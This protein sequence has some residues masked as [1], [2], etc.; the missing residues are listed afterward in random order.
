[1]GSVKRGR[2]RALAGTNRDRILE[3]AVELFNARGVR[4]VTTNHIAEHL[5]ISPGN[6]YYHFANKEEIVR[7]LFPRIEMAVHAAIDLRGA[8]AITAE[9][10]G[11]Y[12]LA[13]LENLSAYPF[14]F[15]DVGYLVSRDPALAELA[16]GLHDWLMAA[17]VELFRLLQRDGHMQPALEADALQAIAI[18]AYLIWFSW[19]GY[20]RTVTPD[21][22]LD[23]AISG[24]GALQSFLVL[25]PHLEPAF[26]ARARAI[27]EQGSGA[28]R[29]PAR[30]A[31]SG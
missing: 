22:A 14:F 1:V 30:P 27:L 7:A 25:E 12:Y 28:R 2:L 18:N 26:A 8:G 11:S 29:P 9:R 16:R 21:A 19:L 24:R 20:V 31:R 13:G 23:R 10:L 6:L 15:A 5:G 17:F 4:D 3:G